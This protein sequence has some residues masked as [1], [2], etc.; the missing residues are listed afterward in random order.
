MGMWRIG[1]RRRIEMLGMRMRHWPRLPEP[2][3]VNRDV[4]DG[5]GGIRQV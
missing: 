3:L 5:A 4:G 1:R 2:G